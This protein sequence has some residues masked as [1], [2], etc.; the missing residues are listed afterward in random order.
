M[1]DN[2]M[3]QGCRLSIKS[4]MEVILPVLKISLSKRILLLKGTATIIKS[5]FIRRSSVNHGF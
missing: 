5:I 1:F 2:D 3:L 4:Q